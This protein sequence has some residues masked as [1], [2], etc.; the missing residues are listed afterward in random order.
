VSAGPNEISG[1]VSGAAWAASDS[2][3]YSIGGAMITPNY[4]AVAYEGFVQQVFAGDTWS[5][6][7]LTTAYQNGFIEAAL[8]IVAPNCGQAGVLVV[9]GGF[10]PQYQS[11]ADPSATSAAMVDMSLITMLDIVANRPRFGC[12]KLPRGAYCCLEGPAVA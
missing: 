10:S 7:S 9:I 3:F 4:A 5:N 6:Q 1:W 11:E 12:L 8:A 2:H